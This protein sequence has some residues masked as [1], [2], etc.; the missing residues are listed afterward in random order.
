[1]SSDINA[2]AQIEGLKLWL[3]GRDMD[4][5]RHYLI[6][7]ERIDDA[8][9]SILSQGMIPV[10]TVD[11]DMVWRMVVVFNYQGKRMQIHFDVPVTT[12]G[13]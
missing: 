9:T 5:G 11:P 2:I 7:Q 3:E 10:C 13:R 1:M 4:M 6:P 8:D 12:H